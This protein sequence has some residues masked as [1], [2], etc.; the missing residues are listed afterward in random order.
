MSGLYIP[1]DRRKLLLAKRRVLL[2]RER[3]LPFAEHMR[4]DPK[5]PHDPEASLYTVAPHL[6]AVSDE[7]EKL[8]R[9]DILRLIISMPP[10]TGKTELAS[11]TFIPWCAGRNPR[12]SFIVATYNSAFSGDFGRAVRNMMTHPR[13][14]DVFPAARLK[15]GH[16]SAVRLETELGA[17]LAFVG[18][19]GTITG[20]GGDLIVVDD[21]IKD[22][23]EA[24]SASIREML[25]QWWTQVL[26]SRLM[27][28]TGRILLIQT[29]W[30]EDDLVGRL[31][32]PRNDHYSEAE[33]ARWTVVNFPALALDDPDRPDPLGRAPGEP[34]WPEK[35]S[36]SYL[37][38][39]RSQDVRGFEALYQGQPAP[40]EGLFFA[41]SD[42]IEYQSLKELPKNLRFYAAS[43]HAISQAQFA[44][45]SAF[46]VFG[47]D[48][49]D[50][51]WIMPDSIL[52]RISAD[53]AVDVML[54]LIKKYRP[55]FWWAERGHISR[56]IG[57][58]LRKRMVE[59]SVYA[60][61]VEVTPQQDKQARAASIK[62]RM[63]QGKV[64]F[65]AWAPWYQEVKNQILTFPAGAHDDFVD[66]LSLMGLG[67]SLQVTARVS[68]RENTG[69]REWTFGWLMEQSRKKDLARRLETMRK[70]W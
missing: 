27:S 28:D 32:D 63:A 50:N 65:P 8:E 57:P 47:V 49:E 26:S 34:L 23:R 60:S 30:S 51:I 17:V 54:N 38:K 39:L 24:D 11:K 66:A 13:Y 25:W 64:R 19:G 2:S 56:A 68:R 35:F 53:Q 43:D 16:A 3:L 42:V 45:K 40:R 36:A 52:T 6:E 59:E 7:L 69:P 37:A 10:R 33:A 31:T 5:R 22:R 67:L 58:F 20:R 29:R 48:D 21:P 14:G 55:V 70:G 46:I 15:Q 1:P 4:P 61:I 12:W 62:G 44:D 41:Q 9:G 18:R